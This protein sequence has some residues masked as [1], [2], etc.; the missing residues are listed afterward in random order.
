M[1]W[2]NIICELQDAGYS[3]YQIAKYCGCS[4]GLI[5]QIKTKKYT[6]D[7]KQQTVSYAMGVALL[8]LYETINRPTE[9]K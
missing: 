2:S 5:S 3:Q 7:G 1:D 8:S 6:K 9:T 4:Q